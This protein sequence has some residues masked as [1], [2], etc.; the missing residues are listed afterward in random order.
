MPKQVKGAE[1]ER[2]V[3]AV[4][5]VLND[6]S[7]VLA[8]SNGDRLGGGCESSSAQSHASSLPEST[9]HSYFLPPTVIA[10]SAN[11][12]DRSPNCAPDRGEVTGSSTAYEPS[13]V[14]EP[15]LAKAPVVGVSPPRALP[16]AVVG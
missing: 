3:I 10:I 5:M 9:V 6:F 8:R 12:P 16:R 14:V 4:S 7:E 11:V 2:E 1:E 13:N 15:A